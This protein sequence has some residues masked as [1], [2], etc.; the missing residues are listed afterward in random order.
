MYAYNW[1]AFDYRKCSNLLS[2]VLTRPQ[3]LEE[4]VS[5]G[6]YFLPQYTKSSP[7]LTISQM[8]FSVK[9]IKPLNT[10]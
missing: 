6:L 3:W 10:S 5:V 1:K 4:M 2:P 9:S 7:I 8:F